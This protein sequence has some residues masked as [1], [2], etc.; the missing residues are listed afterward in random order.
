DDGV[1]FDPERVAQQAAHSELARAL[2]AGEIDDEEAALQSVIE[3]GIHSVVPLSNENV[4]AK[5][6]KRVRVLVSIG[7][8]DQAYRLA[9]GIL[10][11]GWAS[12]FEVASVRL[13]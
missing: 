3:P 2:A 9:F 7:R 4:T 11:P 8:W 1:S 10:E 13:A 12:P 6:R 5:L